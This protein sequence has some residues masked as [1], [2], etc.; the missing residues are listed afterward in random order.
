MRY[1]PGMSRMKDFDID[2]MNLEAQFIRFLADLFTAKNYLVVS[3]ERRG[4]DLVVES[5]QTHVLVELKIH[6]SPQIARKSIG[7]ALLQLSGFMRNAAADEGIL[8]VTQRLD[9]ERIELPAG[10]TLWDLPELVRQ[11]RGHP[12][13][14]GELAELLKG[15]Q[16]GA[17]SLLEGVDLTAFQSIAA[18]LARISHRS[19]CI[20]AL[21]LG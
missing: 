2:R 13:L 3:H 6:R 12:Q 18:E 20:G 9:R 21:N 11:A 10:I 7:N 1:A 17:E 19:R 8:V 16:V 4:P 14:V 5:D 15:L